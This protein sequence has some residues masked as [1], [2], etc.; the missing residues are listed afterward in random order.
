[1]FIVYHTVTGIYATLFGLGPATTHFFRGS[2]LLILGLFGHN[3]KNTQDLVCS[4][5]KNQW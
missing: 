5:Q 4:F 2:F 3:I 1:M